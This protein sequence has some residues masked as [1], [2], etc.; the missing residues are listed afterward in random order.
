MGSTSPLRGG[1]STA[2]AARDVGSRLVLRRRSALQAR[3]NLVIGDL[4][5]LAYHR[6]MA[7]NPRGVAT[8]TSSSA[9]GPIRSCHPPGQRL[10]RPHG[11]VTHGAGLH[12]GL[13][14]CLDGRRWLEAHGYPG[15]GTTANEYQKLQGYRCRAGAGL[16]VGQRISPVGVAP[17]W[18][19]RICSREPPQQRRDHRVEGAQPGSIAAPSGQRDIDRRPLRAGPAGLGGQPG[20]REQGRRVLVHA[21]RQ[22]PRI[23]PA[24]TPSP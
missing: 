3:D 24:C 21:D 9:S 1:G 12:R 20:E 13:L 7:E 19:T 23:G 4:G 6:L 16:A 5:N 8:Q 17:C 11:P 14:S 10:A 2:P 22:H 18:L 15:Y